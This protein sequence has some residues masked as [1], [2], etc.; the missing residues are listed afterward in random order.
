MH[1]FTRSKAVTFLGGYDLRWSTYT[2]RKYGTPINAR[3]PTLY[4][5]FYMVYGILCHYDNFLDDTSCE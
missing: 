3:K 4:V 5:I 2:V 1:M